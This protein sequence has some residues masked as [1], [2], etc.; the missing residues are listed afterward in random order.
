M[1]IERERKF[2]VTGEAWRESGRPF[3][4]RQGYLCNQ[5]RRSVRVRVRGEEAFLT[6]KGETDGDARPE[7]EYPI[8]LVDATTILDT[9]CERPQIE[10]TRYL[11]EV[12]GRVWEVDEF[13]GD[14]QGLI[15]AEIEF[16]HEGERLTLPAWVGAEVTDDP[17]YLNVNLVKHPFRAWRDQGT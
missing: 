16:A 9:L 8:P 15:V 17:R 3:H 4:I 6:I 12:D 11:V 7:F 1:G 14:N 10:K 5:R 13:A 2:L